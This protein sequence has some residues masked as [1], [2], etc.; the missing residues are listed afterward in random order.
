MSNRSR[1][2]SHFFNE[3]C[4][5]TKSR[6]CLNCRRSNVPN[7]SH[8]LW[9]QLHCEYKLDVL[10]DKFQITFTRQ[11]CHLWTG[12][13]RN[14]QEHSTFRWF[15]GAAAKRT[16]VG[17]KANKVHVSRGENAT[18][19]IGIAKKNM[20][21]SDLRLNQARIYISIRKSPDVISF[22]GAHRLLFLA[23]FP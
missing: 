16:H 22:G 21:C 23:L 11:Q 1:R 14:L 5:C 15:K 10:K 13:H 17:N 12:L 6:P 8:C 4:N 3:L 9:G 19:A 7:F 18:K 20:S 2:S